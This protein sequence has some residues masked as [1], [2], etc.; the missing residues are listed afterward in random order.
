L[1]SEGSAR[2]SFAHLAFCA[3]ANF[4][5][6]AALIVRFFLDVARL[7]IAPSRSLRSSLFRPSSFF[8]I[9]AARLSCW[10]VS[11]VMFTIVQYNIAIT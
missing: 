11:S 9:A 5:L 8:L 6:I 10:G 2:R 7:V 1:Y 3:A 4:L